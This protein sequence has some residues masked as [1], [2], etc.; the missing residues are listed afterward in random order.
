MAPS[1]ASSQT[2][3]STRRARRRP[4]SSTTWPSSRWSTRSGPRQSSTSARRPGRATTR[5]RV[6]VPPGRSP[7]LLR[8][9]IES[10]DALSLARLSRRQSSST[11]VSRHCLSSSQTEPPADAPSS[12]YAPSHLP[13]GRPGP[14]GLLFLPVA[15]EGG[16]ARL[17][18][19]HGARAVGAGPALV[20]VR[21]V[22]QAVPRPPDRAHLRHRA[23]QQ[24][25][26]RARHARARRRQAAGGRDR[27]PHP[28]LAAVDRAHGRAARQ[29]PVHRALPRVRG[30]A[31]RAF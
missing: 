17:C 31:A 14:A 24:P 25:R 30:L 29:R 22:A 7:S 28:R 11:S 15:L 21:A 16:R 1:F 23:H 19:D 9:V 26:R 12:L 4:T 2:T 27:G 5:C 10:A 8:V 18:A 6:R 3:R 20:G 13:L